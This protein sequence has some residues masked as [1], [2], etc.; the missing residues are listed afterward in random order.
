MQQ[1]DT[2]DRQQTLSSLVASLDSRKQ[3]VFP[4]SDVRRG[5][6]GEASKGSSSNVEVRA[7]SSSSSSKRPSS[8][9]WWNLSDV[10][11]HRLNGFA[12]FVVSQKA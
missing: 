4:L 7:S 6:G 2:D 8:Q 5:G 3:S 12:A 1:Q 9:L 10:L 11:S